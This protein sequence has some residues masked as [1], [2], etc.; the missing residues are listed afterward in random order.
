MWNY[1]SEFRFVLKGDAGW[2]CVLSIRSKKWNSGDTILNIKCSFLAENEHLNDTNFQR[3]FNSYIIVQTMNGLMNQFT[4]AWATNHTSS[5][6]LR[7]HLY[8]G[9]DAFFERRYMRDDAD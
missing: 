4:T 8:L 6:R 9:A 1:I 5:T 7:Y 2:V 3:L